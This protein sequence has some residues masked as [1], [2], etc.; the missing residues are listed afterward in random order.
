[1]KEPAFNKYVDELRSDDFA[2][3]QDAA[4]ILCSSKDMKNL[5]SILANLE[6]ENP[7]VRRVMLW[8][9]RN[10]IDHI[11]YDDLIKYLMDEDMGVRE[12]ALAVLMDGG[13][14]AI[15][16]MLSYA[17]SEDRNIQYAV[18]QAL[19][20]F[21]TPDAVEPLIKASESEDDEIRETAV[22][23]LGIYADPVVQQILL[24]SLNDK[25]DICLAALSGLKGRVLLSD[26]YKAVE[27]CLK[28]DRDD[29][30][31]AAVYVLDSSC[32]HNMSNDVSSYVRRAFASVTDSKSNL[33]KLCRDPEPSVR[34]AAA[35]TIGK[36]KLKSEDVL[37]QMLN[38]E[39]PGVRRA[40]ATSLKYSQR[41]DVIPAL[42][43]CLSD[44]KPGIRAAAAASLGYIGGD[45]AISALKAAKSTRNPILAGIIKNAL[46]TAENKNKNK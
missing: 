5:P 44:K 41:Q 40:A 28:S 19:G 25:P 14:P 34:T 7:I 21:R 1:M 24:K 6:D 11:E 27:K 17:L 35:D 13:K 39:I 42:I 23:S 29:I 22:M 20:Q 9:L 32:P 2:K 12:A 30:R 45:D 43:R 26:E 4:N 10:Y 46:E 38:D 8:S 16:K 31:A 37:L 36:L 33:E 15:D 3:I 18:V